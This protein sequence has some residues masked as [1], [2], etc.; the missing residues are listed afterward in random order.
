MRTGSKL[1]L[2]L[3]LC[4]LGADAGSKKKVPEV[5]AVVGGTVFRDPGLALPEVQVTLTPDP[6]P[7]QPASII[8]KLTAISDRRGEFAFRVPVTAMRYTI[9]AVAKGYGPQQKSVSVEGEQRVDAT[10]TLQP[11]SK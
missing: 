10:L 11:E 7:G 1:G 5:Y 8:K 3:L 9:R 6:E 2:I 4:A